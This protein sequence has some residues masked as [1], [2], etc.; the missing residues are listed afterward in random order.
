MELEPQFNWSRYLDLADYE[1]TFPTA[2]ADQSEMD[3]VTQ[4][5][6]KDMNF[7]RSEKG[8]LYG[9]VVTWQNPV[10]KSDRRSICFYVTKEKLITIGLSDSI[11]SLVA[12]YSPAHP[13][14]AFYTI[15]ALQLNTY[16]AGIDQFETELFSRQDELRGSINEDSLDSIFALRD[17]IENWSDLIVPFQ[18]LVMAGE[19][20]F[21]DEDAYL[22]D[23]SLKLATKRVHRLLML[24]EH[25]QKDI[26]VL[27]DLS[28][29]VSNFRG[30]EIMKALTIFT[31]VATPTMALGA[32]WGMNFKIMPELEWKYGYALS[33]GLI[34]LSTGGIFYWMRWR[35]WLGALVRM[36]KNSRPKK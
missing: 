4:L 14:A 10:D 24:I 13:F 9:A 36:P 17:T 33:L 27:L 22:E 6:S 18:E 29:T 16:F 2:V 20:S 21:L 32:I 26:E 15:L 19:E 23:L 11:V 1:Q 12:P 5:R 30:N 25:Y 28:T 8:V 31:A 3:W 34:F 35:G 7:T